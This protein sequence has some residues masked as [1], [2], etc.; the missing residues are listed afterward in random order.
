MRLA[1][2]IS[3]KD[4]S[5]YCFLGFLFIL[6]VFTQNWTD[7][8]S[9]QLLGFSDT[10]SYVAIANCPALEVC[11]IGELYPN[12]HL[13]R[14]LPNVAAGT[15]SKISGMGLYR[16][17]LSILWLLLLSAVLMCVTAN[18]SHSNRAVIIATIIFFPYGFRSYFFAPAMIADAAFLLATISLTLSIAHRNIKLLFFSCI[19]GAVSR[20]T[21]VIFIPI[22]FAAIYHD[23]LPLRQGGIS[24]LS[25]AIIG[26]G[27]QY[28]AHKLFGTT[29]AST[30]EHALGLFDWLKAGLNW[31]ESKEFFTRGAFFIL[32]LSP[33]LVIQYDTKCIPLAA[34]CFLLLAI[35]PL[36]AGPEITG[37]NIPRLLAYGVPFIYLALLREQVG[38][39]LLYYIFVI[40]IL[41]L[42]H[43]YATVF[44]QNQYLVASFTVAGM[45][46]VLFKLERFLGLRQNV[47]VGIDK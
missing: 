8:D 32:L 45:S 30:I 7:I 19:L 23:K 27:N 36:L 34:V 5:A 12:H 25:I 47:G 2:H 46:L 38:M 29:P 40:W 4:F 14:W 22:I 9:S 39:K 6:F 11:K 31:E 28:V 35:Q 44:N 43:N 10:R 15:V 24:C 20:Q 17:Y 33:A 1:S 41:S 3:S 42:H 37:G 21:S 13:E 26:L 18:S 16:S